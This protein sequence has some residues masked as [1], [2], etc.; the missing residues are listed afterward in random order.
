MNIETPQYKMYLT[1][2][3]SV[4]GEDRTP[5]ME[6]FHYAYEVREDIMQ[7]PE[8]EEYADLFYEVAKRIQNG[9]TAVLEVM[10]DGS[11]NSLHLSWSPD[12]ELAVF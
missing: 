2:T 4:G 12:T 3:V 5:F 1:H 7:I 9:A 11:V 8:F 10:G 6:E